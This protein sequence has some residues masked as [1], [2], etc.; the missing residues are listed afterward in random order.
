MRVAEEKKNLGK[1][2]KV[3]HLDAGPNARRVI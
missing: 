1:K 2:S 3:L